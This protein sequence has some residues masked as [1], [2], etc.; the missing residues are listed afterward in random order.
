[1]IVLARLT[2]LVVATFTVLLLGC[3]SRLIYFPRRYQPAETKY[4]TQG[5]GAVLKYTTEHGQQQA[6]FRAGSQPGGRIWMFCP[7]NAMLALD[8]E[9]EA[10]RWDAEAGWLFLDYPGYGGNEGRPHPSTIARNIDGAAQALA[11]HLGVSL[12]ELT[13]RMGASGQSLGAAVA[14]MAVDQLK[15]DRAVLIAPF[16]TL[17]EMGRRTVGWPWCHLNRHRYD[18]RRAVQSATG[19]GVRVWIVH[20]VDDEIIP[21]SMARELAALAPE[22]IRL[23][24]VPGGGHNDLW[25]IA[26]QTL[27]RVFH[28]AGA[29]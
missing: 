1:M 27:G 17:T 3:Q 6:Y 22:A 26:P 19:R 25:D 29:R 16:T 2:G 7:G 15:L 18:N 21:V 11:D 23:V 4:W 5:G 20:G 10:R 13:P 28:E 24:E 12:Q 9:A 14:L 8:A